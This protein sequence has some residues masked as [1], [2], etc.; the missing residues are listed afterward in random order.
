MESINDLK[1][2]V[3]ADTGKIYKSA[4]KFLTLFIANN[5]TNLKIV[6][7]WVNDLKKYIVLPEM[8]QSLF[9]LMLTKLEEVKFKI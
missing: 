6:V 1:T 2:D 7:T 5:K 4:F 8:G 9:F 3:I